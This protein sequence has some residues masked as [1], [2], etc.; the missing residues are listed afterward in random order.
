MNG[1]ELGRSIECAG[2]QAYASQAAASK[3]LK[4]VR[5]RVRMYRCRFCSG[6][7]LGGD[8]RGRR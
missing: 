1:H 8:R 3:A 7:H 2:R 6:W 4:H 5:G